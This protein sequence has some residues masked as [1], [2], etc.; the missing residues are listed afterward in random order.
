MGGQ[1]L[2]DNVGNMGDDRIG[3]FGE[4]G[5]NLGKMLKTTKKTKKNYLFSPTVRIG[6]GVLR[7]VRDS[8]GATAP[9]LAARPKEVPV[10]SR[11][12]R[13]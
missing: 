7:V 4:I 10:P 8:S 2:Q 13:T 1:S 9:P 12:A 5:E 3:C 11:H 6:C